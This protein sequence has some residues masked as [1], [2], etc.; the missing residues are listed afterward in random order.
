[1]NIFV[2][3]SNI[4]QCAEY[5][6]DKHIIKMI[7]ESAQML[8]TACRLSGIDAGYKT[9][10][11]NHPCTKWVRESLSNW[12]WLRLLTKELNN[13]Y[14]YR[15]DKSVNHKSYDVILSL[16]LPNIPDKGLTQFPQAMPNEYK[17]NNPIKAYR[18]YY[19][20]EKQ[21]FANWTK[22]EP[23]FWFKKEKTYENTI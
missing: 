12:L 7:L 16:P 23:P 22:R 10:H 4:K 17:N 15:Y 19:I 11:K 21:H 2:L 6:T 9:T 5:H 20:G 1:M 18:K 3:D 8:S 14:R 13:E